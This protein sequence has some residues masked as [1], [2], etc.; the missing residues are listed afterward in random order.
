MHKKRTRVHA[1]DCCSTQE[2][3]LIRNDPVD[4]QFKKLWKEA[5]DGHIVRESKLPESP[6]IY[7]AGEEGCYGQQECRQR[8]HEEKKH[9][10]AE[11]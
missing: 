10:Q 3:P 9:F 1:G 6:M 5:Y 11:I 7:V 4:N 2:T 8:R